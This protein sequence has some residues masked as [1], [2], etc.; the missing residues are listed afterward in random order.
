M[1]NAQRH[2]FDGCDEDIA[3]LYLKTAAQQI[4]S[5][6]IALHSKSMAKI[7]RIAHKLSGSSAFLGLRP[8]ASLSD[9]LAE[10]ASQDQARE[11]GRLLGLI[12]EEFGEIQGSRA[13]GLAR[14][15]PAQTA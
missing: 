8:I 2:D 14:V 7:Q 11:A 13:S 6:A 15:I 12:Q 5:M 1:P 10:A 9:Q 3:K 4:K